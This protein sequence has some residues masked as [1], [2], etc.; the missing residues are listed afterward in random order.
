MAPGLTRGE[1]FTET[2]KLTE[3]N[4]ADNCPI[5]ANTH[6]NMYNKCFYYKAALPAAALMSGPT[7]VFKE[8]CTIWA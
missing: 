8:L 5:K 2:F 1:L 3:K 4:K 6:I 7:H